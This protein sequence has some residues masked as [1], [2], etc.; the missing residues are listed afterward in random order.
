MLRCCIINLFI[1]VCN[2]KPATTHMKANHYVVVISVRVFWQLMLVFSCYAK[3][4]SIVVDLSLSQ[5]RPYKFLSLETTH[6]HSQD[7]GHSFK[8]VRMCV[9]ECKY[10]VGIS[11][12]HF[13]V[14]HK[15]PNTILLAC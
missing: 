9:Y 11:G 14:I 6:I 7:T 15:Q 4:C 10:I 2:C 5:T 12:M 1:F 13:I 8:Y 3:L